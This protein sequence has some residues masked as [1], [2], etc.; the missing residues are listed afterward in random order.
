MPL[1]N[2]KKYPVLG[3]EGKEVLKYQKLLQKAGSTIKANGVFS[4]GMVSAIKA[5]QKKSKLPQTGKL[6]AKTAAALEKVKAV[7]K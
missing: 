1:K 5:F 2:L 7:K 4:I 6:N 3:D